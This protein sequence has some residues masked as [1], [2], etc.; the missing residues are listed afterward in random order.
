MPI[1]DDVN[2]RGRDQAQPL[3]DQDGCWICLGDTTE[4]P[5]GTF[6]ACPGRVA[7]ERCLARWCLQQAGRE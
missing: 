1:Q 4:G 2:Q 6:C 5:L 3:V 7:H